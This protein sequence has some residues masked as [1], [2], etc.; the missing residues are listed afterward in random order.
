MT[1]YKHHHGHGSGV[2]DLVHLSLPKADRAWI[3]GK[4][5]KCFVSLKVFKADL[6]HLCGGGAT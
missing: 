4:H 5:P 3:A 6:C 2:G 1:F